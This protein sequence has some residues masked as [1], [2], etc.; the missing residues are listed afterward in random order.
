MVKPRPS[1]DFYENGAEAHVVRNSDGHE[2]ECTVAP[3]Q[4]ACNTLMMNDADVK[5]SVHGIIWQH[6]SPS[7]AATGAI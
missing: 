3:G 1:T 5:S 7:K 4:R 6:S 2:Y